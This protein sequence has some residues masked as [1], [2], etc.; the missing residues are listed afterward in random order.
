MLD[1]A[2]VYVQAAKSENVMLSL[3]GRC[4][5]AVVAV[6]IVACTQILSWNERTHQLLLRSMRYTFCCDRFRQTID[7]ISID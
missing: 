7:Q 5:A 4:P 1:Q 3:L 2:F 6:L